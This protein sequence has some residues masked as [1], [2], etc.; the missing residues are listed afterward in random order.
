MTS[1]TRT[2]P[3]RTAPRNAAPRSTAPRRTASRRA[4]LAVLAGL[5][6]SVVGLGAGVG[7]ADASTYTQLPDGNYQLSTNWCRGISPNIIDNP[8]GGSITVTQFTR[9]GPGKADVGIAATQSFWGYANHMD[10]RWTNLRTHRTGVLRGT[11]QTTAA[12][13][14]SMKWFRNVSFGTGP[15]RIELRPSNQNA[16]WTLPATT[17]SDVFSIR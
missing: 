10:I 6:A 9:L 1:L 16:L 15:V 14:G 7:T 17:C 11:Q 5:A 2:A 4:G 13:G 8:Y 3:R 12:A